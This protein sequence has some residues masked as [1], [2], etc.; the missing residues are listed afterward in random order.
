MLLIGNFQLNCVCLSPRKSVKIKRLM[1]DAKSKRETEKGGC[2][3][4]NDGVMI[5]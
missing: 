5:S 3:R 4:G 1:C 2:D